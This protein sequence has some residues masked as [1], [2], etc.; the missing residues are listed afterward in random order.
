MSRYDTLDDPLCYPQSQVLRNTADIRDQDDLDQYEQLMF[1]TRAEEPLPAGPLD[2][3]FYKRIHKHFFQDVYEWAG[4]IR[5]IRTGKGGN[6][7]C[8]PEFIQ[9]EMSRI[10]TELETE[11]HLV[12]LDRDFFAPRAAYF[13]SEIN[14]VHPFREGNGRTQLIF[15]TIL[16]ENAAFSLDENKLDTETFMTAMIA[17]FDA[18][19]SPLEQQILAMI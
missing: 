17:S 16:A 15:L 1:H 19:L 3:D 9:N 14:A 12:G 11:N 7:F 5:T 8:F 6:W 13:I 4:E 2:F 18:N 10:F